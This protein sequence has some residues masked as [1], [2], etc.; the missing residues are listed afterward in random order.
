MMKSGRTDRHKTFSVIKKMRNDKGY[1]LIEMLIAIAILSVGLLAV[2]TMQIS[3]IRVN[4]TARRMTRRATIA[5]DRL[6]YIMS[7]KYT[8]AVL[9]SGS[10]TDGEVTDGRLESAPSGYSISWNV[11]TGGALPPLT[12]LIRVNVTERGKTTTMSN[13]KPRL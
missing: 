12:K 5:Q 10:H 8:H 4:D 11:S 2:A 7:L 3:S 9:T 13:I 6:E 1:T